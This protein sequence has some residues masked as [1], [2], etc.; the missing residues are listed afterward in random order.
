[1]TYT[2][3]QHINIAA[4]IDNSLFASELHNLAQDADDAV[5]KVGQVRGEYARGLRVV[6]CAQWEK[7]VPV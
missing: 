6:H 2:V 7:Q 1:M 4:C 3:Q 5:L